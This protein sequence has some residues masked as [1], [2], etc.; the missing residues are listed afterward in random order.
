MVRTA[1][2]VLGESFRCGNVVLARISASDG[3]VTSPRKAGEGTLAPD[4]WSWSLPSWRDDSLAAFELH[5]RLWSYL[6][7]VQLTFHEFGRPTSTFKSEQLH[8]GWAWMGHI[9]AGATVF[10]AVY[11]QEPLSLD[12]QDGLW[13]SFRTVA[14]VLG[15]TGET[16]PPIGAFNGSG[17]L[18][19]SDPGSGSGSGSVVG[20]ASEVS[21]VDD[22]PTTYVATLRVGK[23]LSATE[24]GS[25]H[26]LAVAKAAAAV[27]DPQ[28]T[29]EFAGDVTVG[30]HTVTIVLLNVAVNEKRNVAGRSTSRLGLSIRPAGD[31]NGGAAAVFDV[32]GWPEVG[33]DITA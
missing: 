1:L 10:A 30:V 21:D 4:L 8:D 24:H 32:M 26:V 7:G 20:S 2:A 15:S 25:S 22:E 13:Q 19:I 27:L 9:D 14:S 23:T 28:P 5:G 33:L 11:S 3:S 17:R 18:T 6:Q 29:I 16:S 31:I 12:E